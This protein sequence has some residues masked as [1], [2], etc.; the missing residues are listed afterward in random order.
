MEILCSSSWIFSARQVQ[1]A[2]PGGEECGAMAEMDKNNNQ[3]T[4]NDTRQDLIEDS[5]DRGL[6]CAEKDTYTPG[7]RPG[8][9]SG[10]EADQ[11]T[12]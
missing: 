2:Q 1:L 9:R 4:A 5:L 12:R 10:E 8:A 11:T 7:L 6:D 3:Q